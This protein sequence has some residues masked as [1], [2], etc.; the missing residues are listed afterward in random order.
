MKFFNQ[1]LYQTFFIIDSFNNDDDFLVVLLLMG[2]IFFCIAIIV[3]VI[4]CLLFI[5]I[6]IGL[7]SAGIISASVLIGYQQK[8]V[9]KGFR[10]FFL[11]VPII[12]TSVLSIIFFCVLNSIY[13]WWTK[14]ICIMVGALFGVVSGYVLGILVFAVSKKQ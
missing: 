4:I 12:G 8:S 2:A 11:S 6:L 10:T 9:S 14:D 1:Y 13:D 3:G 5:L 7:I